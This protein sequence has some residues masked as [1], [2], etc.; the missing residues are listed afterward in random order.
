VKGKKTEN[1]NE[2]R[3][4][5]RNPDPAEIE[6]KKKMISLARLDHIDASCKWSRHGNHFQSC[7]FLG[8]QR[9]YSAESAPHQAGEAEVSILSLNHEESY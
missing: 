5:K 9:R 1:R 2:K 6:K 8:V 7:V 4:E 3:R